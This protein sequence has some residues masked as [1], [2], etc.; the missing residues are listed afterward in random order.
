MKNEDFDLSEIVTAD[1]AHHVQHSIPTLDE[2][3]LV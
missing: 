2:Y 3:R 1:V